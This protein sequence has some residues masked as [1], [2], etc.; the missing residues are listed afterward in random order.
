MIHQALHEQTRRDGGEAPSPTA[1][2]IDSKS[3][4]TTELATTRGFDGHHKAKGRKR[5]LV[6]DTTGIPLMVKVTDANVSD[7]QRAIEL[8]TE[9]Y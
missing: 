4:K 3:V 5:H 1:A 2:I 9:V 8:L 6:K 7:N